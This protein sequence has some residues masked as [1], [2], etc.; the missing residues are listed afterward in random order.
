M[1]LLKMVFNMDSIVPLFNK[2]KRP[3]SLITLCVDVMAFTY[4]RGFLRFTVI[5]FPQCGCLR[6]DPTCIPTARKSI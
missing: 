5:P 4:M 3:H 2:K 1:I 6:S